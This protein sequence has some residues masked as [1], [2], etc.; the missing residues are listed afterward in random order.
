M[1]N[2]SAVVHY[3]IK[4]GGPRSGMKWPEKT[5]GF[6]VIEKGSF[7]VIVVLKK[8]KEKNCTGM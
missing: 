2:S 4:L 3:P 1:P 7:S 8:P 5:R 6:S